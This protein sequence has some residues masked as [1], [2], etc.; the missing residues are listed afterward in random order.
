M[1]GPGQQW[2]K[3]HSAAFDTLGYTARNHPPSKLRWNADR[4]RSAAS[5]LQRSTQIKEEALWR[6]SVGFGLVFD[7]DPVVAALESA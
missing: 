7:A 2:T 3:G 5:E 6:T 1:A 4:P